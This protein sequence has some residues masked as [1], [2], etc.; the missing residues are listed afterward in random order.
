MFRVVIVQ[1][2]APRQAGIVHQDRQRSKTSFST[3]DHRHDRRGLRYIGFHR[4]SPSPADVD[5]FCQPLAASAWTAKVAHTAAPRCARSR[6]VARPIP[7]APPVT[8]AT[9][10]RQEVIFRF[11]DA[12]PRRAPNRDRSNGV[13]NGCKAISPLARGRPTKSPRPEGTGAK[14]GL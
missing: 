2:A 8:S 5:F 7:R 1:R 14:F 6:A 3:I 4:N 11:C 12:V 9:W 13:S 10:S